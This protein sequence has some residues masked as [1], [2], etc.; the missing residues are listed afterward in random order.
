NDQQAFLDYSIKDY[1]H[2]LTRAGFDVF[3]GS[4]EIVLA[5]SVLPRFVPFR[6]LHRTIIFTIR[7]FEST[8]RSQK[9]KTRHKGGF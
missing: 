9:Q 5:P 7:S 3:G 8:H 4:C 6:E 2:S 1:L